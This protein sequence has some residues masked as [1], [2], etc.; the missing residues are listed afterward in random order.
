MRKS[1][2]LAL[3]TWHDGDLSRIGVGSG[4]FQGESLQ[5]TGHRLLAQR[6]AGWQEKYPDVHVE[7]QVEHDKPRHRLLALSHT[8][9]LVV[10]GCRGR[11]GFAGLMLGSTSQALLHHANC[12]VMV[13]RSGES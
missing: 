10:V 4:M 2:L 1:H 11:G 3:H 9:Q 5:E 12:P 8:A 7:R 13:V 6:L